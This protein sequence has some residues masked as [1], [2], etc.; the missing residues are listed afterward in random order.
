MGTVKS[1]CLGAEK[2]ANAHG[3]KEPGAEYF[4]LAALELPDGTAR[5]TFESVHVDAEAFRAA[6]TQQYQ[7]A[8]Q[9]GG[10]AFHN[11]WPSRTK[12][13]RCHPAREC[14]RPNLRLK[15]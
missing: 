4:V 14:I 1:L 3:Q 6:I 2:H 15:L 9:N 12:Q 5:K 13:Y 10:I 7:D 8:L 11:I